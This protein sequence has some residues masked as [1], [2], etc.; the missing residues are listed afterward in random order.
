[1][2]SETVKEELHISETKFENFELHES[3]FQGFRLSCKKCK[4]F[5]DI[6]G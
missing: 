6:E 5:V 4:E 1:M 2:S 3:M